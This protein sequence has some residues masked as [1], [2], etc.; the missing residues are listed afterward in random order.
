MHLR[1]SRGLPDLWVKKHTPLDFAYRLTGLRM[2]KLP[3]PEMNRTFR[4][5][6][7]DPHAT[8]PSLLNE[9]LACLERLDPSEFLQFHDDYLLLTSRSAEGT[10]W[11]EEKLGLLSRLSDLIEE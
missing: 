8:A 4:V 5:F 1:D 2:A 10:A 7:L 6:C 11:I 9:L 3:D